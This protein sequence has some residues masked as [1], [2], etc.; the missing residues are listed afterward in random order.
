MV[1][2]V[3]LVDWFKLI[4]F[5]IMSSTFVCV[6]TCDKFPISQNNIPLHMDTTS[7]LFTHP[8]VNE[9]L[10]WSTLWPLQYEQCYE[11]GLMFVVTFNLLKLFLSNVTYYIYFLFLPHL[12][13]EWAPLTKDQED[14]HF[15][16]WSKAFGL[17]TIY[18]ITD[19]SIS[20]DFE[21]S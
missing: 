11:H 21:V 8:W 20:Y 3:C 12:I 14:S 16:L 13:S 15:P 17:H 10:G 9:H 7:Y 19:L 4:S 1:S 5:T 2:F 6:V 18:N